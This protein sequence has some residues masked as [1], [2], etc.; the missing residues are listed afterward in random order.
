[1][2]GHVAR[3]RLRKR[4]NILFGK[5]EVK[6]PLVRPRRRWEEHIKMVLVEILVSFTREILRLQVK[7]RAKISW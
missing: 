5:R 1:M 4:Y 7:V 6:R 2:G 3:M